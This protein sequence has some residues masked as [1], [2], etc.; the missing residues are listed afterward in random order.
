MKNNNLKELEAV[1]HLPSAN[2]TR[3]LSYANNTW[4]PRTNSA[5]MPYLNP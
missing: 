5:V 4:A 2:P 3:A 1:A